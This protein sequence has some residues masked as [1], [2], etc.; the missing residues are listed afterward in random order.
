MIHGRAE[1]FRGR[2]ACALCPC[3][4]M[5]LPVKLVPCAQRTHRVEAIF[6]PVFLSICAYSILQFRAPYVDAFSSLSA[7]CLFD[8]EFPVVSHMHQGR[9][10][11]YIRT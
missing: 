10:K 5:K 9:I 1:D 3:Y 7:V 4:E 11:G 6:A 8:R 2:L